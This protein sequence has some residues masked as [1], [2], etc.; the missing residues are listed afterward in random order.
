MI[1]HLGC[2]ILFCFALC[3]FR[4]LV[5]LTISIAFV[6]NSGRHHWMIVCAWWERKGRSRLWAWGPARAPPAQT[7]HAGPISSYTWSSPASTPDPAAAGTVPT[8]S[9]GTARPRNL[10]A[11][12]WP[13]G[14]VCSSVVGLFQDEALQRLHQGISW[15]CDH[16][17]K[18]RRRRRKKKRMRMM[19]MMKKKKKRAS[20]EE[21]GVLVGCAE[22]PGQS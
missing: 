6:V 22:E 2:F 1:Y 15:S 9:A 12:C 13:Q 18:R 7:P 20:E 14:R 19:M 17:V 5:F 21:G 3:L 10:R 11:G 16:R 4:C 8:S